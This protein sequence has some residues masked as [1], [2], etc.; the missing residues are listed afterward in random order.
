MM[1]KSLMLQATRRV[2]G[3]LAPT[4]HDPLSPVASLRVD[5][6]ADDSSLVRSLITL[7]NWRTIRLVMSR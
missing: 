2:N 7:A 5:E 6:A 1:A 3:N 4:N